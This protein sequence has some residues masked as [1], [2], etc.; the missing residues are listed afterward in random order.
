MVQEVIGNTI[1]AR[2]WYPTVS[3]AQNKSY[4]A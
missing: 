1:K 2:E 4:G 3:F